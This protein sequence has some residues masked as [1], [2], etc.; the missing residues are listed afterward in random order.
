MYNGDIES[1]TT[2][3]L[4]IYHLESSNVYKE[5]RKNLF[6]KEQKKNEETVE[7]EAESTERE[8]DADMEDSS[9]FP[10]KGKPKNPVSLT[11]IQ[12]T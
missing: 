7:R 9:I 6:F 11:P 8:A 3:Y 4:K 5:Y 1:D 12:P 10:P 2:K